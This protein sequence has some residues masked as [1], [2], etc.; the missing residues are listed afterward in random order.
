MKGKN[1]AIL[2]TA[3]ITASLAC[4]PFSGVS[5]LAEDDEMIRLNIEALCDDEDGTYPSYINVTEKSSN[6]EFKTEVNTADG[7]QVSVEYKRTC[8]VWYTHCKHTGKEKD[9]C[10]RTLNGVAQGPCGNWE[11]SN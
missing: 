8:T 3:A 9:I 6:T 5:E 7:V 1:F 11:Q 4:L 10:Y 2:E